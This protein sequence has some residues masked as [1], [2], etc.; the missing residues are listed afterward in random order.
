MR[1]LSRFRVYRYP[2]GVEH[3]LNS[4]SVDWCIGRVW[5]VPVGGSTPHRVASSSVCWPLRYACAPLLI[6]GRLCGTVLWT[7]GD[8]SGIS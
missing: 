3:D 8:A 2:H 5:L 7:V 4:A 6:V 1:R